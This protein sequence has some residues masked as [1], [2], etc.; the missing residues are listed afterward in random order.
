M[1]ALSRRLEV[2]EKMLTAEHNRLDTA[3]KTVAPSVKRVITDLEKEIDNVQLL[4]KDHINNH[5]DLKQQSELLQTIPGIGEKTANLLLSEIEF[6]SFSSARAVAAHA[7]V[8]P[9]RSQS[10][11]SLNR[12]RLSKIGNSR[13][14]KALYF[15]A[16]TALRYN[17]VISAFATRLRE[18]GKRP[19]QVVGAA[20]RKLIHI[21]Y[22]VIKNNRPFE[23]TPA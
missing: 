14:R 10:G 9:R 8:T 23:P 22:G 20:M 7:G 19:M 5:P 16:I 15:P 1:Q 3:P 12:T 2:L 18:N 13:I 21:A 4:I 6:R 11:T 17:Q